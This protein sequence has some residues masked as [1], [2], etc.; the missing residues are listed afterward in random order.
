MALVSKIILLI[1]ATFLSLSAVGAKDKRYIFLY[2]GMSVLLFT[3]LLIFI[4]IV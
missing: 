3:L 1:L 4:K 2:G